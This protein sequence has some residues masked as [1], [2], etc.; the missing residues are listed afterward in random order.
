MVIGRGTDVKAQNKD[1]DAPF[2]LASETHIRSR[3]QRNKQKSLA[4]LSSMAQ[5]AQNK[6]GLTPFR[7]ALST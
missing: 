6:Y 4:Y 2:Y 5:N 3:W 7:L 1:G